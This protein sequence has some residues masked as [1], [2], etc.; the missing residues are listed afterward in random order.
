MLTGDKVDL[1]LLPIQTCWP[2]EPSPLIT[3]P[4]VVTKG[5]TAD[6]QDNFNLGIYRMQVVNK[7]TTLMRWLAHRGGAGHHKRWK[8]ERGQ[9][10]KY[11]C[12]NPINILPRYLI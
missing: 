2:N 12:Q 9:N 1:S 3:W 4:L 7:K 6:K 10:M 8:E 5:P 11:E